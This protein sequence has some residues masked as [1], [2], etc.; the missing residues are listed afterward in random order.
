MSNYTRAG[1]QLKK[2]EKLFKELDWTPVLVTWKLP[3]RPE[4]PL[5]QFPQQKSNNFLP[6]VS[7]SS[8][9]YPKV[10]VPVK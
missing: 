9:F 7:G 4:R 5:N 1:K 10:A 6:E 3:N 2:A 8:R